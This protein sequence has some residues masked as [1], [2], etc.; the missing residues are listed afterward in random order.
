M[1]QRRKAEARDVRAWIDTTAAANELDERRAWV[2]W[3]IGAPPERSAEPERDERPGDPGNDIAREIAEAVDP[4]W[5]HGDG[6]TWIRIVEADENEVDGLVLDDEN[7][8]GYA[9]YLMNREDAAARPEI[10]RGVLRPDVVKRR[11]PRRFD[12]ATPS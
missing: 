1:S 2:V 9:P 3:G 7:V 4:G 10:Q 11:K 6:P 8:R 5:S 12:T